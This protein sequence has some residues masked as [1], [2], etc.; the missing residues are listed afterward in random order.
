MAILP[1][2]RSDSLPT[3]SLSARPDPSSTQPTPIRDLTPEEQQTQQVLWTTFPPVVSQ[4][5]TLALGESSASGLHPPIPPAARVRQASSLSRDRAERWVHG[6]WGPN[7]TTGSGIAA[8]RL[9]RA[10]SES[11]AGG[12]SVG[13]ARFNWKQ[14]SRTPSTPSSPASALTFGGQGSEGNDRK[15]RRIRARASSSSD[16]A[17]YQTGESPAPASLSTRRTRQTVDSEISSEREDLTQVPRQEERSAVSPKAAVRERATSGPSRTLSPQKSFSEKSWEFQVRVILSL[18]LFRQLTRFQRYA[19]VAKNLFL[20]GTTRSPE[21]SPVRS[22]P[23]PSRVLDPLN[24]K[25][26]LLPRSAPQSPKSPKTW[27][28]QGNPL[29]SSP[30]SPSTSRPPAR[31]IGPE[32]PTRRKSGKKTSELNRTGLEGF[33]A[34]P[35]IVPPL[36]LS[37]AS[38]PPPSSS[39]PP[40]VPPRRVSLDSLTDS[41]SSDSIPFY[42]AEEEVPAGLAEYGAGEEGRDD[43]EK[44]DLDKSQPFVV[45][46]S[47]Y[48]AV[49]YSPTSTRSSFPASIL[50]S[51]LPLSPPLTP[52]EVIDSHHPTSDPFSDD[53]R[54]VKTPTRDSWSAIDLSPSE[55]FET[56]VIIPLPASPIKS[57]VPQTFLNSPPNFLSATPRELRKA[58]RREQRNSESNDARFPS[59]I[60]EEERV[61]CEARRGWETSDGAGAAFLPP[62]LTTPRTP[63]LPLHSR[64][65]S[66]HSSFSSK[67]NP[68]H[69][70]MPRSFALVPTGAWLFVFGFLMPPCWW[71]GAM[72]PRVAKSQGGARDQ[73][74]LTNVKVERNSSG[75]MSEWPDRREGAR[76][77]NFDGS[78]GSGRLSKLVEGSGEWWEGG[79]GWTKSQQSEPIPLNVFRRS[80]Y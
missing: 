74:G 18:V 63:A 4:S 71:V 59:P 42:D 51:I 67:Q 9:R 10:A 54:I 22:P 46:T 28:P 14:D 68:L 52:A 57:A 15:P 26:K 13:D 49:S 2:K 21:A 40:V 23:T 20:S 17:S 11:S 61:S 76:E 66:L 29:P 45:K 62:S 80:H 75:P 35:H 30:P 73:V 53:S 39:P 55:P 1:W 43:L 41:I 58:W 36:P 78:R 69:R 65:P 16:V 31:L 33:S 47:D 12:S 38:P 34:F 56:K 19:Q 72:Y 79:T 44:K 25:S 8:R 77:P 37:P 3:D 64:R 27:K 48:A 6:S 50:S 5:W 32:S 24:L 70:L 60:P 7:G